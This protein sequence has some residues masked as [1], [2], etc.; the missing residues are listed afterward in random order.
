MRVPTDRYLDFRGVLAACQALAEHPLVH[1]QTLGHTDHGRPLLLLEVGHDVQ[2]KPA[3]WLDG[4]THAVEWTGVSAA[5]ATVDSWL[6]RQD[7]GD[8][9][10]VGFFRDHA[11]FVMPCMSPDGYQ[12]MHDGSPYLRSTL[13]PAPGGVRAG[14]APHDIDGDGHIGWM[15]WRH[16]AGP[17]VPDVDEPLLMRPRTLDDP[18]DQAF[19]VASE[20]RFLA[21][22]GWRWVDA[23]RQ[24]GLDL[25]RNFPAHWSP[26]RMFGMDGGRFPGSAP[27]SRA[28]LDAVAARPRIA[29]A[30]S[31]HTYTGALLTQPYRADSP[32]KTADIRLMKRLAENAVAGTGYR[33]IQVHPDFTYDPEQPIRGVWADTLSTTFGVPGYTLEL[34][35]PFGWAGVEVPE[36]ASFFRDPDMD[37]IGA[38][39]RTFRREGL[40]K[41][42]RPFD[43]PQLGP[44]ELGGVD[45]LHSVRNPPAALLPEECARGVAVADRLR[46]ALPRVE[47]SVAVQGSGELRT[48]TLR[49]ENQGFLPTSGLA[50]AVER[51]TVS[52]VTATLSGAAPVRGSR[53][54]ELSHLGG[55]GQ[56]ADG[57]AG[58]PLYPG[59]G[60]SG[61]RCEHVWTVRPAG[62]IDVRWDAGRGGCGVHRVGED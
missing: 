31:N 40:V 25:N 53:E 47:A 19:Y 24:F 32:L 26:F 27:E 5:L 46:K 43:H 30:L 6:R 52:P 57:L 58:N 51:G 28:V 21:W 29:A 38:L 11:A 4:G 60:T 10:L 36:P 39:L 12:A 44:V 16:P 56:A 48:V 61:Q 49:L 23:P 2:E 18:P 42:W 62:P 35:N 41:D 59:L 3:L 9:D 33:A 7:A 54:V 20:G 13:R 22:D 14:L 55:W 34:W 8:A 15:R 1:L 50:L 17:W 45:Y 37:V